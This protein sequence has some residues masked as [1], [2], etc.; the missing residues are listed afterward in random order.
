M[1]QFFVFEL[2]TQYQHVKLLQQKPKPD[3]LSP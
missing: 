2:D 3:K 1:W